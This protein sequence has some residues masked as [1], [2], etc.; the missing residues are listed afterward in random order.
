MED[1]EALKATIGGFHIGKNSIYSGNK[2]T[3][4]STERGIY[5]DSNG[6]SYFG[7]NKNFIRFFRSDK[8]NYKLQISADSLTFGSGVSVEKAFEDIKG[9][10][11]NV[12]GTAD[13]A[14]EFTD[15]AKNNFGYQYK[16]DIEIA[17]DANTY[18]PVMIYGGDQDVMREILIKRSWRDKCPAE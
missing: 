14:K 7:D 3:I 12:Q 18:Y 9:D 13:A 16:A 2:K 4:D 1:L 11:Q 15:N 10:I 5:F 17:G 8:D 6:Q